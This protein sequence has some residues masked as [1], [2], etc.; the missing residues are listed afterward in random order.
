MT[1]PARTSAVEILVRRDLLSRI[2]TSPLAAGVVLGL[3]AALVQAYFRVFPPVAYG[4]CMVCHPRDLVS[5]IANH[6]F[7]TTWDL[8]LASIDGPVLTALG[9]AAGAGVAARRH[10]ELKV[11]SARNR[12]FMLANGFLMANLGLI[13]G[14][15]PIRIVL[16]SAYGNLVAVAGWVSVAIGAGI[17]TIALRSYATRDIK[18]V[19]PLA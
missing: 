4:V 3:G 6:A 18:P 12:L 11:R 1:T 13:L 8:N 17:G 2:S 9:V 10:G 5:W 15:C 16:L 19:V 14:S 7:N